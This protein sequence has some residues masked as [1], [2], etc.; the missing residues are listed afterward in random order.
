[1]GSDLAGPDDGPASRRRR[2]PVVAFAAF[3]LLTAS[4]VLLPAA[5]ALAAVPTIDPIADPAAIPEDSAQQTVN[6]AG[7]TDGDGDTQQIQI[8]ASS[9]NTGLIPDPTVTYTSP[10][11]TGSLAYTPVPNASGT[12]L[13]T[14]TV[15]DGGTDLVVGTGGDDEVTVETFTV[16]VNPVNDPPTL[17]AIA[18]PAAVDED[19]AQQTVN[20]SGISAGGGESQP[21]Q[22]T[23]TSGNTTVIP[24]P[25]VTYT[26]PAATGS[27]AYTPVPNASGSSLITVTVTDGGLDGNLGTAGD[28]GTVQRT[29]TVTVNPVNDPPTLN[30]ITPSTQEVAE[31]TTGHL[32]NLTGISAGGGESQPLQVTASSSA[33]GVVADPPVTYTSPAATGSLTY[34]A[35]TA[36]TAVVTV[37][38]TDG[39][40]DGNLGT[41]GDNGTFSRTFT[42]EVYPT[43]PV[44]AANSGDVFTLRRVGADILLERTNGATT[45]TDAWPASL[46]NS[47]TITGTGGADHVTVS[48]AGGDPIPPGGFAYDAAGGG[49]DL[50]LSGGSFGTITHTFTNASDGSIDIA[51]KTITYTGLSPIFDNLSATDRIF[52][53]AG[54]DDTI[55]LS[56]LGAGMTRIASNNGETVD[57]TNPTTSL[58]VNAGAG[59]DTIEVDG[60]G[61]GFAATATMNGDGGTNTLDLSGAGTVTVN[62]GTAS[63]TGAVTLGYTGVGGLVGDGTSATLSNATAYTITGSNAGT[64]GAITFSG[65]PNLSATT[66]NNDLF[67]FQGSG[68]VTG[69]VN[70]VSGNGDS[71]VFAAGATP[72][73][74]V[75]GSLTNIDDVTATD[76]GFTLAG[77]ASWTIDAANGGT[78]DGVDFAGFGTLVGTAGDDTFTIENTGSLSGT[79]DGLGHAGGDDVDIS[80]FASASV[81]A[82]T[83]AAAGILAGFS[84]VETVIGDGNGFA[85]TN[86]STWSVTGVDDGTVDGLDFVDFR[87]LVGT[88]GDD[89]F[90]F[91]TA[92]RVATVD[93]GGHTTGDTIV[94]PAARTV[95]LATPR[96]NNSI[97]TSFTGIEVIQGDGAT[98]TISGNGLGAGV[99][100]TVTGANDGTVGGY[101]FVDVPNLTG[102]GHDDVFDLQAGS[103]GTIAGGGDSVGDTLTVASAGGAVTVNL[104]GSVTGAVAA[105]SF[106]QIEILTGDDGDDTLADGASFT[107]SGSNS[108]TAGAFTFS[109]FPNLT[110]RSANNDVFTFTASGSL[111]GLIDGGAGTGDRVDYSALASATVDV[112][113]D[114]TRIERIDGDGAGFAISGGSAFTVTGADDGTVDGIA[115]FDFVDLTGTGGDDTFTFTGAGTLGGS[116]DGGAGSGDTLDVSAANGTVTVDVTAATVTPV[117]GTFS[118]IESIVGD[119]AADILTNG[120]AWSVTGTNA[121]TVDGLEFSGF[122]TLT[123]TSGDD[124]FDF[125]GGT[126]T[127]V[128]GGDGMD[129]FTFTGAAMAG[130]VNGDGGDDTFVFVPGGVSSGAN[131]GGDGDDTFIFTGGLAGTID[132]G[133]HTT[134]DTLDVSGVV[135]AVTV[136]ATGSVTGGA[137]VTSF[138]GIETAVGDDAN[139]ALSESTAFT[140]SGA[141]AGTAGALGF[142]GFPDLIG[143]IGQD[144]FSFADGGSIGSI[145]GGDSNDTITT[146]AVTTG[147]V[148]FDVAGTGSIFGAVAASSFSGI[149]TLV[150][151]DTDDVLSGATSFAITGPNDGV[152]SG[153]S[154]FDIPH[155]VGTSGDD[156]FGL[157]DGSSIGSI[158]GLAGANTLSVI[159]VTTGPVTVDL[160]G[161]VSDAVTVTSFTGITQIYGDSVNDVLTNAT[162]TTLSS[163]YAG[164]ANGITFVGFA[165]ITGSSGD[166]VFHLEATGSFSVTVDGAA[167]KDSFT[168]TTGNGNVTII[169]GDQ[170]GG[171]T[172]TVNGTAGA[173]TITLAPNAG[174]GLDVIAATTL[175]GVTGVENLVLATGDDNDVVTIN[176]LPGGGDH[177]HNRPCGRRGRHRERRRPQLDPNIALTVYGGPGD[178]VL[179][180]SAG[181][182]TLLGEGGNDT[183]HGNA[184]RDHLEGGPGADNLTAGPATTSSPAARGTTSTSS[185]R[186]RCR[187]PTRSRNCRR[188]APPIRST[189]RGSQEWP[190]WTGAVRSSSSCSTTS[191]TS[192]S[193]PTAPTRASTSRCSPGPSVPSCRTPSSTSLRVRTTR[194]SRSTSR[195]THR[196]PVPPSRCSPW[197][198]ATRWPTPCNS[199]R[200]PPSSRRPSP[201]APACSVSSSSRTRPT[202]PSSRCERPTPGTRV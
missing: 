43:D 66:G 115:F 74:V 82:A 138:T 120:A 103:I 176:D 109:G 184:G 29:F 14:V 90:T 193:A 4:L 52:T 62:L 160:T 105:T 63:V 24:H 57:F 185:R 1:V 79:I 10:N 188:R 156:T 121:G 39:G 113:T 45:T 99:T 170:G 107:I 46:L 117:S 104:T 13:I 87:D 16:T 6:M 122:P 88:A 123:G 112:A 143:T 148:T 142:S 133:A 197:P 173:D 59:T 84:N 19:A 37:T 25:T 92:G 175:S 132:G 9:G 153:I 145:T 42:V 85:L 2:S 179:I 196:R 135:A 181:P 73:T 69:T 61:A 190:R 53:Y 161:S 80:D 33:T 60:F 177:R 15:T 3:V 167:G 21:L 56:P 12:A 129:T 23:A 130:T 95:D 111:A 86:G 18:D 182:D 75:L 150:G 200:T 44:V 199:T 110:G 171:D 131:N 158:D 114:I 72:R 68:T 195:T 126:A 134:G 125:D 118:G 192:R 149:E 36:G 31:G 189:S 34:D 26:S 186:P 22:V 83:G 102:T 48:F 127:T 20:L 124:G 17:N 168:W 78:V 65:F 172:L 51:G 187:P 40:L 194:P 202:S 76:A 27:L 139:D 35:G 108:G 146:A 116:I 166:D 70:G 5:P 155:L 50:T 136:D 157:Y 183:L 8:T 151:D 67:T 119:G 154:W 164:T 137:D 147:A 93:G 7:I 11:A 144:I 38:V 162:T 89:T 54:T 174:T 58:T 47:L 198:T 49:D 152:S 28:N 106:S 180:G 32:V 169:G 91:S 165:F 64:A 41:P 97:T 101:S 178:D 140:I 81:D 128:N 98:T 71:V 55:T 94:L 96:V 30:A 100:F 159:P 191:P 163:P 141:N 77:G 201:R